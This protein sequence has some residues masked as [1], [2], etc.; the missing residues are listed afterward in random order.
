MD[1]GFRNRLVVL[2][3]ARG[4]LGSTLSAALA[5]AGARV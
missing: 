2:T 5:A 3:G 1:E 4:G